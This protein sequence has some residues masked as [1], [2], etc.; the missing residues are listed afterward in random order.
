MQ[1]FEKSEKMKNPKKCKNLKKRVFRF[2]EGFRPRDH[3]KTIKYVFDFFVSLNES[4][5]R[6]NA[7][8]LVTK[9]NSERKSERKQSHNPYP[10][11]EKV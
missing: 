2:F 1:F 3:A 10:W 8:S 4:S 9:Q 6:P 5:V 7:T 11:V